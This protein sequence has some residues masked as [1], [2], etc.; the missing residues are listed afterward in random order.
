[1]SRPARIGDAPYRRADL[2][3]PEGLPWWLR[4][5]RLFGNACVLAF[6]ALLA[7]LISPAGSPP[8]RDAAALLGVVLWLRVAWIAR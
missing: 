2:R 4:A 1:M 3:P 8:E 7:V 6:A 5:V